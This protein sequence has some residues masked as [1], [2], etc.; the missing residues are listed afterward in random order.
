MIGYCKS[1]G[2][3]KMKQSKKKFMAYAITFGIL[4]VLYLFIYS[5][6]TTD[7]INIIQ[8]FSS[9]N[10][11]STQM[12]M[13]VGNI[14]CIA[15]TFLYGTLFIKFGVR[16]T[17]IPIILLAAAGCIGIAAADGLACN[18][19]TGN[20]TLFFISLFVVR[21][22]SMIFQLGAFML[23]ANWFIRYRGQLMGIIT[24][25]TTLFTVVG[26]S[27]MTS[28]I[29]NYWGGDYR[30]FYIGLAIL[31]VVLAVVTGIG[32]KDTPEEAGLYPDGASHPPISEEGETEIVISVGEVLRRKESWQL[33]IAF[34]CFMFVIIA[35][36]SSMALRFIDL[37]D[38]PGDVSVWLKAVKWLGLGAA[39]GVPMHYLFGV[40]D[41]KL[42]SLKASL[43]VGIGTLIPTFGLMLQPEGGSVPLMIL[44]GFGVAVMT[45]GVPTL[46]PC[47]T[48]YCFGRREYQSANRV[49]MSIQLIPS[50]VGA[51]MMAALINSGRGTLA[52]VILAV[53]SVIGIIAIISMFGLKDKNEADRSYGLNNR[54]TENEEI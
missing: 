9:W 7:Q 47:I 37:G 48:A 28:L 53:I 14:V 16:R 49:I 27:V 4:G 45:G 29:E 24:M 26:T 21:C 23:C 51:L 8:A 35:S 10:A 33:I 40:L 31:I 36:M 6:M 34:G 15:L 17:I 2:E 25:G 41:D 20:Y 5:G 1:E 39:L 3:K 13:T 32:F 42:G 44:W 46:H 18:G 43:I 52:Y 11:V 22:T 12:P 54:R 19:G 38:G 30:P 50:T